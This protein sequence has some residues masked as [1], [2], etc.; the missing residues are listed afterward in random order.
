LSLRASEIAAV[1]A[2]L[3]PLVGARLESARAH[4]ERL[5][6]LELR[7]AAGPV[8]LL[9][10]AEPD[11]TRIHAARWRPPA[12]E[13]PPPFQ[14]ALRRWLGGAR[15]AALQA[16]PGDRVVELRF[17][18][19]EGPVSLVAELTGRHGNLLLVDGDGVIRALAGRNLSQRRLLAPGAPYLPPEPHDLAG[20]GRF[21]PVEG[22]PFPVSAAVEAHYRAREEERALAEA[23][24]RL[25]EPLR[26][27]VER[28][29]RALERLADE[30]ARVPAADADRAAAD[31]LKRN[32]HAVPR[33]AREVRLTDWTEEGAREVTLALDPALSPRANMERL[34]RRYKRIAE[35]AARV[36]ARAAEVRGRLAAL[37]GL[38]A[39]LEREEPPLP[40]LEREARRLGAA[41]RAPRPARRRRT[42]EAPPPYRTFHSLAGVPILVGKGA[43][44][45]DELTVRVARGNDVW[46]H[47]RG[48][49]GAHVVIR[50]PKGG[51]PDQ[52]TL[53][54]AAHLAAHFSDARGETAPEV[55]YT[56]AKWVRKARGAAPGAVTYSQERAIAV[57]MEP[58]RVARLLAAEGAAGDGEGAP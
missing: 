36:E 40:R 6:T 39:E 17:E 53:L 5:V 49:P 32:L 55:V 15:L 22:E 44:E 4:A 18:R 11:L 50:L 51:S 25:R 7:G 2:E 21:A 29:R 26:A 9:V 13:E 54:D 43:A 30:A 1:V 56:R 14:V 57:R 20:P 12:A 34:Y 27:A 35:S 58:P 46:L 31:L 3:A 33:G 48:R 52:E 16:R 37:Q 24:R 38:L 45:N 47:A 42:E 8:T 10:S 28:S 19:R 23:R 41:P